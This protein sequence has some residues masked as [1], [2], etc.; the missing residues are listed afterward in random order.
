MTQLQ[1]ITLANKLAWRIMPALERKPD[2]VTLSSIKGY[3]ADYEIDS[4]TCRRLTQWEIGRIAGII[5]RQI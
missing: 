2:E 5:L 1:I 3:L 4:P